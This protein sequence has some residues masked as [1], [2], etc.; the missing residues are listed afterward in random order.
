MA[1][2]GRGLLTF[3]NG[4]LGEALSALDE[5]VEVFDTKLAMPFERARTLYVRGQVHRRAGHRRDSRRDLT[6]AAAAFDSLGARVWAARAAQ[7][8]G[9]VAGRRPGSGL[10]PAE[11]AVAQLAAAGR[12]NKEIAAELVI[13]ARTVESQLSSV[14]RKLGIRSRAQL[15]DRLSRS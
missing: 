12:S 3:A 5:A 2:R 13:S 1:R 14:Y 15:R 6:E 11:R 8:L 10:T 9:K 7:D 4:R